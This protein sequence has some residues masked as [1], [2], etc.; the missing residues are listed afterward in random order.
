MISTFLLSL[1][2][3]SKEIEYNFQIKNQTRYFLNEVSFD[4]CSGDKKIAI[5]P[6]ES[7]NY[8][9]KYKTSG[10]NAFGPGSLC[11]TVLSYFD[12]AASYSNTYGISIEIDKLN[13]KN[14]NV[15]KISEKSSPNNSNIFSIELE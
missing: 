12:T 5:N 11:V 4:W 15:I 6:N 1:F 3:C 2:S 13:R 14:P 10:L 7:I 9:L 8:T